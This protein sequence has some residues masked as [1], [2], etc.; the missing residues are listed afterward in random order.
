MLFFW[1]SFPCFSPSLF[2]PSVPVI[3][4]FFDLRWRR[5]VGDSS[6]SHSSSSSSCSSPHPPQKHWHFHHLCHHWHHRHHHRHNYNTLPCTSPIQAVSEDQLTMKV[7]AVT[8]GP[9]DSRRGAFATTCNV[10]GHSDGSRMSAAVTREMEIGNTHKWWRNMKKGGGDVDVDLSP[11][12]KRILIRP[13]SSWE[14]AQGSLISSLEWYH[15]PSCAML[16]LITM[17]RRAALIRD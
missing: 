6:S 4:W 9:W 7:A 5:H 8:D 2:L 13:K 3:W 17:Q 15:N 10:G 1:S 14:G 12:T 16:G 11:P